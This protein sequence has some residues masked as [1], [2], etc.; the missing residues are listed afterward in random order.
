MC[1]ASA[2]IEDMKHSLLLCL[3]FDAQRRDLFAGIVELL[4]SFVQIT[5]L[6]NDALMQCLLR[7]DQGFSHNL[8]RNI[9]E[10]TLR[11]IHETD[12]FE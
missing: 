10:L 1:P 8:D 6:S 4:Q 2:G 5:D 9:L 3:A 7:G 11:F 12:R